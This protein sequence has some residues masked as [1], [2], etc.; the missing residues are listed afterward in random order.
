MA[1]AERQRRNTRGR[2]RFTPDA[3]SRRLRPIHP[4]LLLQVRARSRLHV[5]PACTFMYVHSIYFAFDVF[6]F[7]FTAVVE[8]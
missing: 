7:T 2:V 8:G 1:A 3:I 5:C 4:D 6:T